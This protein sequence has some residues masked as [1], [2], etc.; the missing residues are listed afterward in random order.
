MLLVQSPV[1]QRLC[2]L[3]PPLLK[4]ELT[5]STTHGPTRSDVTAVQTNKHRNHMFELCTPFTCCMEPPWQ[6]CRS[7]LT[8]A[9]QLP[10]SCWCQ[11]PCGA[12]RQV[13]Q[14]SQWQQRSDCDTSRDVFCSNGCCQLLLRWLQISG[15]QIVS[16]LANTDQHQL[17]RGTAEDS[18]ESSYSLT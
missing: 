16:A 17:L 8:P 3:T 6:L 12:W 11:T 15:R 10:P 5:V 14:H 9:Q 18:N 13:G 2:P 7:A 4:L 1:S